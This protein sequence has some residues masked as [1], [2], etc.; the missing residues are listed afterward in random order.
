MSQTV[1]SIVGQ[2]LQFP[3]KR[4]GGKRLQH[5]VSLPC[6]LHQISRTKHKTRPHTAKTDF[7]SS[8]KPMMMTHPYHRPVL[9]N[10]YKSGCFMLLRKEPHEISDHPCRETR[11][12]TNLGF[13]FFKRKKEKIVV[14]IGDYVC[15]GPMDVQLKTSHDSWTLF[16]T[17]AIFQLDVCS[18]FHPKGQVHY[19]NE[20]HPS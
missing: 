7:F 19:S 6:I 16:Y 10:C 12:T 18:S 14:Q 15:V 5:K 2:R 3:D 17:V 8:S 20:D 13:Y 1:D 9:N 4:K 11:C